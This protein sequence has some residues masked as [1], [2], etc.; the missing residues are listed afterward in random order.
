MGT[1][2]LISIDT[3]NEVQHIFDV[4]AMSKIIVKGK[5][6][7]QQIFAVL[8]RKD[9]NERP[10]NLNELRKLVNI[11]G[12]F[13]NISKVDLNESEQKFEILE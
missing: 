1:D 6:D 2:I 4:V 5:S 13:S 11:V 10:R 7:P 9:N 12:D 8:G 3:Y